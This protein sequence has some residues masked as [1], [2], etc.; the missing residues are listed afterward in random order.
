MSTSWVAIIGA[1]PAGLMAAQV[2][3]E[4][5]VQV[6][7]FDAMRSPGRK[8]L[9]AGVGGLNLTHAEDPAQFVQRFL[10]RQP[11]LLRWIAAFDATAVR[12]W[13]AA[14]GVQTF[15]GSS[16]R[17]F[18]LGMKAAPLLRA[19]LRH[20]HALGVQIHLQH[21][22]QG[23]ADDGAVVLQDASGVS[24][25]LRPNA[26]VLALGGG[27][28]PQLGSDAAWV[29]LLEAYGVVVRPLQAANVGMQVAWSDYLRERFAGTP[30]KP[31]RLGLQGARG[32]WVWQQGELMITRHG[33]EG[34]LLYA[35]SAALRAALQVGP[36][37]IRLDLLPAL[38]LEALAARL[39]AGPGRRSFSE[40]L[41]RS[42]RLDPLRLALLTEA[43]VRGAAPLA[44]AQ[45]LKGLPLTLQGLR[46]L[47]EAIST[48]G[49]VAFEALDA[50]AML[51]ALPGVYCAGEMLDWEAPTGGYLLTA[52]LA[53][54]RAAAH[55]VLRAVRPDP[56]HT[57]AA[58]APAGGTGN[59]LSSA[60]R[61][62]ARPNP[63]SVR[64]TAG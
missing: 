9:R 25:A 32:E 15:V 26:T 34:G 24:R 11:Q 58:D 12:A 5:G 47:A 53:S 1:G 6:Q 17:V 46:P 51:Q 55:G 30:L 7:V 52:C 16:G 60:P 45:A 4:A 8:F 37:A 40:W 62:P 57:P 42:L 21:R 41:R 44:L 61:G 36:V 59:A 3:A 13:A 39:A 20:L 64:E 63:R 50:D 35:C 56:A 10:P 38:S 54:G 28:W 43:G 2:L 27:S 33:L 23:F 14:L 29:P 18:P 49:G 19:W 22:W 31:V 48:A